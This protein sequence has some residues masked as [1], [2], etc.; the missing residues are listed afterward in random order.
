MTDAGCI[1]PLE[2]QRDAEAVLDLMIRGADYIRLEDGYGPDAARAEAF[3]TD[4]V[5]NG[6][7]VDAVKIGFERDG[8]LLGIA[9][10]GFGYPEAA[11]AYIGLLMLDSAMRGGGLGRRMLRHLENEAHRRGVNRMLVAVLKANPR[12]RAF[13]ER[14][15]F[16]AERW[17]APAP[18]DPMKHERLRMVRAML[19]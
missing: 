19:P 9:D 8:R 16:E 12:G 2:A 17:F 1:R 13:W 3:F 10:M 6:D 4:T 5:P 7:P 15:G 11:D 14:E 18:D